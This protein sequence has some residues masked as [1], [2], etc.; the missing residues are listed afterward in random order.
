MLAPA[1]GGREAYRFDDPLVGAAAAD[2][3]VHVAHDLLSCWFGSVIEQGNGRK[4][5]SRRTVAA[6]QGLCLH[7]RLLHR[8]QGVAAGQTLN[9]RDFLSRGRANLGSAGAY[10]RA[11]DQNCARAALSF[12]TAVLRASQIQTVTEY[13][14]QDLLGRDLQ[15]VLFSVD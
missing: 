4:N 1:E 6:L 9:G 3:P 2:V 14:Q 10:R 15:I 5:H 11:V 12:A 8:M 7:K 13:V